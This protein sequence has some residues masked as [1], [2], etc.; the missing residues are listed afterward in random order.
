MTEYV[1][2]KKRGN[3]SGFAALGLAGKHDEVHATILGATVGG[4]VFG[5]GPEFAITGGGDLFRLGIVVLEQV[6]EDVGGPGG[7]QL[8]V[9]GE[10][11]G[12]YGDVVGV[13]LYP[14]GIIVL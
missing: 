11:G 8:P 12:A 9:G 7:R 6:F 3:K 4:G 10:L 2:L 13:P 14:Q 5:N 1:A